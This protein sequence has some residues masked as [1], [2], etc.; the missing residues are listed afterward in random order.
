M[1]DITFGARCAVAHS[2]HSGTQA[3]GPTWVAARTV[4]FYFRVDR[5]HFT[6]DVS[7]NK[8]NLILIGAMKSGTTTLHDLLAEHPAICMSEPKEPCFFVDPD[9]LKQHWP[10]MWRLGFWKDEQ[11]Y[12]NLFSG[13]PGARLFGESSTDYSKL[14]RFSGVV[15]KIAAYSPEARF[16]YIMRDPIERTLSHYWHMVEHRGEQRGALE[17]ITR[18]SHYTDVS[19]YAS[20]LAP[21][22][23]RFGRDRVYALTFEELKNDTLGTVR[24]VYDWLGVDPSFAP[25]GLRQAK[26]V[27]PQQVTQKREAAGALDHLRHSAL[28]GRIGPSFPSW[29]RGLGVTLVERKISRTQVDMSEVTHYLRPIQLRQTEALT[30]MLGRRFDEWKTLY[31]G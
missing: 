11:A 15:E 13:K 26:N 4:R 1:S 27:T 31:G 14:P 18:N 2:A 30:Q 5:D 8:P 10:E 17:A 21:Y 7:L 16:V 12:L 24:A 9:V 25:Q 29:F 3:G 22:I 20:Q 23:E 6:K 28:W 19:H